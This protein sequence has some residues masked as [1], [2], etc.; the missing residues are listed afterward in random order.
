M[1]KQTVAQKDNLSN[2]STSLLLIKDFV[3][4]QDDDSEINGNDDFKGAIRK[5]LQRWME[6]RELDQLRKRIVYCSEKFLYREW[7]K[8]KLRLFK[9]ESTRSEAL[10]L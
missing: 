1:S 4:F 9:G 5:C 8:Y 6:S 3:W 7:Y 10:A 2:L